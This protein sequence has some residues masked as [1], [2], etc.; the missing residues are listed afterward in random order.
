MSD[1]NIVAKTV[2]DIRLMIM[3]KDNLGRRD[4]QDIDKALLAILE[5]LHNNGFVG[6]EE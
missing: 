6:D 1:L 3:G 4:I 2:S 5:Y